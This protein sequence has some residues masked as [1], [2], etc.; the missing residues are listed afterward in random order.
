MFKKRYIGLV[1]IIPYIGLCTFALNKIGHYTIRHSI[2]LLYTIQF[3][4]FLIITIWF[5]IGFHRIRKKLQKHEESKKKEI[6]FIKTVKIKIKYLRESRILY[7]YLF[8][9]EYLFTYL[10][11]RHKDLNIRLDA[12]VLLGWFIFLQIGLFTVLIDMFLF[13]TQNAEKMIEQGFDEYD[14]EEKEESG[15]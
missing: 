3:V 5:D 15:K 4:G 12:V 8:L 1:I 10:Y 9:F 2:I 7:I 13:E 6:D 14:S 11:A